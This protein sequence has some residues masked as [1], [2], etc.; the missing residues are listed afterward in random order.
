M[1][2]QDYI[3]LYNKGELRM[4][5]VHPFIEQLLIEREDATEVN[6]DFE[7]LKLPTFGGLNY[8]DVFEQKDFYNGHGQLE[9]PRMTLTDITGL[10]KEL[11]DHVDESGDY[12]NDIFTLKLYVD[13]DGKYS[14]TIYQEIPHNPKMWLSVREVLVDE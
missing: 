12:S 11:E 9:V 2:T 5:H 7:R 4:L 8:K 1:K 10:I 3:D 6:E 14:G 13:D